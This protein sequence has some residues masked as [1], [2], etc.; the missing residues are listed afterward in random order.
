MVGAGADP[1]QYLAQIAGRSQHVFQA[2]A[3]IPEAAAQYLR[4]E[5]EVQRVRRGRD[6]PRRRST[7][8]LTE[9]EATIARLEGVLAAGDKTRGVPGARR[10][11][12]RGSA[13]SRR[14][15]QIRSEL[16]D[17]ELQLV[18]LGGE[19]ASAVGEPQERS[20][21]VRGACRDPEQAAPIASRRRKRGYDAIDQSAADIDGAI[22]STQAIAVALRKYATDAPRAARRSEADDRRARSTSVARGAEAI[23][24]E[25]DDG[26]ARELQLGRDLAGVGDGASTAAREARKQLKAAEDA[27]HACSPGSPARAATAQVAAAGRARRSRGRELADQLD[28]TEAQIDASSIRAC[29]RSRA[30]IVEAKATLAGLQGRARR[31]RGRV[32]DARRH[33]ARR[34]LQ[35]RQGEVL[36]HRDPQRRRQRRRRV[37][38]K[39]RHRRRSQAAQPVAPARAQAAARTS[40]RTSSTPAR[41]SRRRRR[42]K[43]E[44]PRPEAAADR[45]PRQGRRR[46][47]D[48]A[49]W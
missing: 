29:A 27:E 38:A 18:E 49:R 25:L 47:A 11:A 35:G 3:P 4:D 48:R 17:Q 33:R 21:A 39:G 16:A 10:P 1:A 40:S 22:D 44:V 36:R 41:R 46:S 28:Q 6:R 12:R 31:L 42:V 34:E 23:E 9:T 8:N 20:R 37:V 13:R 15:D 7:T 26:P 32:A 30:L 19:L 45:Q 5:P 2:A 24:N 43:L 14:P